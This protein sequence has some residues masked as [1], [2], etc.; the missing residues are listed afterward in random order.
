MTMRHPDDFE[1]LKALLARGANVNDTLFVEYGGG[2]NS[3][4]FF[5]HN[6]IEVMKK[7]YTPNDVECFRACLSSLHIDINHQD[8]DGNTVLHLAAA[9]GF[10]D[11]VRVIVESR[12]QEIRWDLENKTVGTVLAAACEKNQVATVQYLVKVIPH[13]ALHT[14]VKP[15]KVSLL[16][17]VGKRS[18]M[19]LASLFLHSDC[20]SD[21]P[22]FLEAC[23]HKCPPTFLQWLLDN[24]VDVLAQDK[25]VRSVFLVCPF[26]WFHLSPCPIRPETRR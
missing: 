19:D 1:I 5:F 22:L 14:L 26:V 9:K 7:K 2:G 17:F 15:D 8:R 18:Y 11:V 10:A 21:R 20:D 23:A 6:R 4:H 12:G 13:A 16:V 25:S 3:H 24:N